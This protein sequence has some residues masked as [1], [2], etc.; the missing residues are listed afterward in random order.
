MDIRPLLRV[1]AIVVLVVAA[2]LGLSAIRRRPTRRADGVVAG[3]L[4]VLALAGFVLSSLDLLAPHAPVPD[5]LSVYHIEGDTL[6]AASAA[7]GTTRWRYTVS[8]A[9]AYP[10][11]RP[12]VDHGMVYLRT[13]G[14]LRALRASDGQQ[15]WTMPIVGRAFDQPT[16]AVDQGV[17]YITAPASIIALRARDGSPLWQ[18][19]PSAIS[20]SPVT[21]PYVA[22]GL[23][24][25]GF[26]AAAATVYAL[27]THDGTIRWKHPEEHADVTSLAVAEGSVYAAFGTSES[28]VESTTIMAL[29]AN[30]GAERWTYKADG[31]AN[32]LAVTNNTLVVSSRQLGLLALDTAKG[33]L[34]WQGGPGVNGDL[35][36]GLP[37]VADGMVYLSGIISESQSHGVALAMDVRTGRERWRTVLDYADVFINL[38]G[39]MLYVGGRNAYGLRTSDGHVVWSYASG[40]Q[41]YQPVVAGG[42]VFVG[43]G[44][45]GYHLF[46]IGSDDFLNALDAR[47]GQ[48]YWRTSFVPDDPLLVS[49]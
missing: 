18:T 17:I 49:S 5:A 11:P 22:N 14:A 45:A 4:A 13:D 12:L 8:P 32:P 39:Q 16:P 6:I 20:G 48:L 1:V 38:A 21:A 7:T 46:G 15:M 42:V 28:G 37:I 29:D 2:A 24:Y 35:R 30:D 25:E 36:A 41:F 43:S 34:L 27:D 23:A 40:T 3:T 47:T 10:I 33:R 19:A 31:D 44:S 26:N 9:S